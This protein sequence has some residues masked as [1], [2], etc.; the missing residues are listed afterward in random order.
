VLAQQVPDALRRLAGLGLG[1]ELRAVIERALAAAPARYLRLQTA[2]SPYASL[3]QLARDL[4]RLEL[5]PPPGYTSA[6]KA[7]AR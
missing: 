1:L 6:L 5:A 3:E 7:K 2:E 4:A